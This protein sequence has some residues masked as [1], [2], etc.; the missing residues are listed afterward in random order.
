MPMVPQIYGL[1]VLVQV[2]P[3]L[4]VMQKQRHFKGY[5]AK[6]PSFAMV[7]QFVQDYEKASTQ[8]RV[9][10]VMMNLTTHPKRLLRSFELMKERACCQA[11]SHC[12]L[13]LT[14]GVELF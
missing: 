7:K 11:N 9:D 3:Q 10:M 2:D 6:E 13:I 14:N 1:K 4:L 12:L 5:T 8:E